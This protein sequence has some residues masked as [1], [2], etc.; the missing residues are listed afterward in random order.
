MGHSKGGRSRLCVLQ[1]RAT[2]FP[3]IADKKKT[4]KKT[5]K[6]KTYQMIFFRKSRIFQRSGV[7]GPSPTSGVTGPSPTRP[8][9]CRVIHII[10]SIIIGDE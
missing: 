8:L 7:T 2:R 1:P 3:E 10:I 5:L 9:L 6:K 4:P